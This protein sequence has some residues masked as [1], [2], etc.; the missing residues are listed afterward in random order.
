MRGRCTW[1]RSSSARRK[2]SGSRPPSCSARAIS[3]RSTGLSDADVLL[4]GAVAYDPKVVTIWEGFKAYF[5]RRDLPFDYTLYSNYERQVEALLDDLI[6]VAWNSP[7]AWI[8]AERLPRPRGQS[9]RAI[10]MRDTDR[11]LPPI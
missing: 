1:S 5:G 7:L 9:V 3:R 11:D 4:L 8:R 6:H 2:R 10:A